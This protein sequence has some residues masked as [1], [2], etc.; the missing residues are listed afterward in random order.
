MAAVCSGGFP[1]RWAEVPP[2]WPSFFTNR[3]QNRDGDLLFNP[4]EAEHRSGSHPHSGL[5]WGPRKSMTKYEKHATVLVT[6]GKVPKKVFPGK[7]VFPE[8]VFPEI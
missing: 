4:P 6:I 7:K 8:K 5:G 1:Q 2:A 3:H